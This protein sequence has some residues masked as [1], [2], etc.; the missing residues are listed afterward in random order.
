MV[1]VGGIMNFH[2]SAVLEAFNRMFS[3]RLDAAYIDLGFYKSKS[4]ASYTLSIGILHFSYV[5]LNKMS[6][7]IENTIKE[8]EFDD[9][10]GENGEDFQVAETDG[11]R[12][13]H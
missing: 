2:S 1:V 7:F 4:G 12:V 13:L 6:E 9:G 3:I 8:M 5:N 11:E 10:T